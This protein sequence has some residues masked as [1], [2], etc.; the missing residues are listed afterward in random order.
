MCLDWSST[1]S[2][3]MKVSKSCS[4]IKCIEGID[5]VIVGLDRHCYRIPIKLTK[6]PWCV[7][8][9]FLGCSLLIQELKF[10]GQSGV[11]DMR[12]TC[13]LLTKIYWSSF[14]KW[15]DPPPH[16]IFFLIFL[17]HLLSGIGGH[18]GIQARWRLKE[19]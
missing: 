12:W 5:S 4:P 1:K 15:L 17:F 18:V 13:H 8:G 19:L 7:H 14:I 10:W 6:L 11:V 16:L 9:S 2:S 3:H